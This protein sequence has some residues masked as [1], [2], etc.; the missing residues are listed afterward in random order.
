MELNQYLMD[1][2][3]KFEEDIQNFN[4]HNGSSDEINTAE[5]LYK[6]N[7]RQAYLVTYLTKENMQNYQKLPPK[8]WQSMLSLVQ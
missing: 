3:K 6:R 8:K 1:Q 7:E 2:K 5:D 4:K